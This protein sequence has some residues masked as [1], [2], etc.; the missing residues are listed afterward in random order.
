MVIVK[1]IDKLK[2]YFEFYLDQGRKAL[3][4]SQT[5]E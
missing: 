1:G 2:E 4:L 5:P 3:L